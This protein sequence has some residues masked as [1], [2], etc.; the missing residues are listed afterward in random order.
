MQTNKNDTIV[1]LIIRLVTGVGHAR[2][3]ARTHV[4]VVH[5]STLTVVRA[6]DC[7]S[8]GTGF[9]SMDISRHG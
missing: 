9:E 3:H 7:Q 4:L 5:N 2:M 1:T 8:R 6:S